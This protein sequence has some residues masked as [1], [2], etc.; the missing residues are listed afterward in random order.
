MRPI[1][2]QGCNK[3]PAIRKDLP[4]HD[5]TGGNYWMPDAILYLNAQGKL[6]LGG[7][8][9]AT[10]I[11]AINDGKTRALK[12]LA[13]AVGLEVGG[14]TLRVINRTGHKLISGYPEGRRMWLNTK[15]FD[16]AGTLLRE[17]GAYGPIS[18][19]LNGQTVSVNTILNLD[20]DCTRI[21]EAHYG[22]TQEWASQLV[23]LGINQS[24][25]LGYDRI[26][27]QPSYTLGQ[28]AGQAPGTDHETFHF[29][30][31]NCVIED[32]RIPMA[33]ATAKQRSEMLSPSPLLS[34]AAP[35]QAAITTTG[36][37]SNSPLPLVLPMH[38]SECSTSLL[39]GSISSS[40]ILPTTVRTR[41]LRTRAPISWKLG[42]QPRWP[43]HTLWA[44]PHGELHR[45]LR[46]STPRSIV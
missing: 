40:C 6:R 13:Q 23:S 15:W 19:S 46:Q 27:G 8:L 39:V 44:Q 28:L 37:A 21:Y 29:A 4:L 34:T 5:M 7:S 10:Q 12:Q 30:L 25:V 33:S 38:R 1:T 45:L 26:T 36:T 42:A 20:D 17:D 14:N 2:G 31:N 22:M 9:T 11:A 35:G 24:L 18:V 3:N 41:F 32:N 43:S 16:S